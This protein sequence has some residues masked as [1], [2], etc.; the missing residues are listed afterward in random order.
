MPYVVHYLD[1]KGR[2]KTK[3]FKTLE[4]A[5]DFCDTI[6]INPIACFPVY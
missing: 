3:N 1:I 6:G 2:A 4:R 5:D